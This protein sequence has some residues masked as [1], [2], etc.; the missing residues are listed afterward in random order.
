MD[1]VGTF[2]LIIASLLIGGSL[3]FIAIRLFIVSTG[4]SGQTPEHAESERYLGIV[5]KI[6]DNG[7]AMPLGDLYK[8]LGLEGGVNGT[9]FQKESVEHDR[10][11]T[12]A[13]AIA[14][15]YQLLHKP[16]N[17]L[18]PDE[19]NLNL[20]NG[21]TLYHRINSTILSEEQTIRR[22]IAY[23]GA[24]LSKGLLRAGTLSYVS[25]D[26]KDFKALDVGWL[27]ISNKRIIFVGKERNV[28]KTWPLTSILT[29]HLYRDG[30]IIRPAN[31]KAQLFKFHDFNDPLIVQ[32][33]LFEFTV[34]LDRILEGTQDDDLLKTDE[35]S[36]QNMGEL[37]ELDG[38]DSLFTE[39]AIFCVANGGVTITDLQ[40]KLKIG[41]NRS[42]K[43]LDQ[44]ET[45]G[46]IGVA[47]S[48]GF[49]SILVTNEGLKQLLKDLSN[50]PDQIKEIQLN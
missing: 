14:D 48:N 33:G 40:A 20:N 7:G 35:S 15:R 11:L 43:I 24:R 10:F 18:D 31:K 49:R 5:Q 2:L 12:T 42:G 32:D 34:V 28:T 37:Y 38:F 39:S 3:L 46:V 4:K 21:E 30:I 1:S 47:D 41:F 26:V 36:E 13:L 8:H 29:Y 16:L 23:S 22:D 6:F 50:R 19:Y 9:P 17:K 25:N 45:A 44:L 27:F